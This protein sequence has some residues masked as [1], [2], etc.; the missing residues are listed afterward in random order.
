MGIDIDKRKAR[1]Y[2]FKAVIVALFMG[3][4]YISVSSPGEKPEIGGTDTMNADLPDGNAEPLLD[5]MRAYESEP[6]IRGEE[7]RMRTLNDYAFSLKG[8][9]GGVSR[10][11]DGYPPFP[12][13]GES[14][15]R[16]PP[17]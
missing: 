15:D 3:L 16:G 9:G 6:V 17:S 11:R 14:R 4:V 1:D 2:A 7:R 8:R 13:G 10:G 5:K 12:A